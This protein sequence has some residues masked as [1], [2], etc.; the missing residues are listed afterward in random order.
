MM[1]FDGLTMQLREVFSSRQV[2]ILVKLVPS[3]IGLLNSIYNSYFFN[4]WSRVL[5]PATFA[6]VVSY[7]L[8]IGFFNRKVTTIFN[9]FGVRVI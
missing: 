3:V 6:F 9:D 5:V 2:I 7:G 4:K 1:I 8:I